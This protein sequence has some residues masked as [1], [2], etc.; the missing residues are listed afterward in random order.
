MARGARRI[1]PW[2]SAD[3]RDGIF[4]NYRRGDSRHPAGRIYDALCAT[5]GRR[6]VFMDIDKIPAGKDF[7]KSSTRHWRVRAC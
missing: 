4:I 7:P 6:R 2:T 1:W 5:F 3:V